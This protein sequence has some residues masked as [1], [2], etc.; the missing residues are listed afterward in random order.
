MR[1]VVTV[2]LTVCLHANWACVHIYSHADVTVKLRNRGSDA[3]KGDVYGDCIVIEQ[4]I[5]N[6]GCRLCKIKS[7][8]GK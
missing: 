7:K 4:R 8:S 2:V 5:T 1:R 3:Y 6:D